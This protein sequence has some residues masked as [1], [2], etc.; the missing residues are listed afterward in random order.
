MCARDRERERERDLNTYTGRDKQRN[1]R[2][3][4]RKTKTTGVPKKAEV[5]EKDPSKRGV[6]VRENWSK[7]VVHNRYRLLERTQKQCSL[8]SSIYVRALETDGRNAR[9]TEKYSKE[10]H[11]DSLTSV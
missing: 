4:E 9:R 8:S 6:R 5:N 11:D 2:K 7:I 10:N 3:K 1:D